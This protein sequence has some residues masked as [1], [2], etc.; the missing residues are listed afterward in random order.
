MSRA[1]ENLNKNVIEFSQ[2]ELREAKEKRGLR[3]SNVGSDT[4]I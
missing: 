3:L 1:K 2:F 4:M